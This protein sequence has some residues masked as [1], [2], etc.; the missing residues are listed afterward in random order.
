MFKALFT[1]FRRHQKTKVILR[2]LQTSASAMLK[3]AI[4]SD[5][6]GSISVATACGFL[7]VVL[8]VTVTSEVTGTAVFLATAAGPTVEAATTPVATLAVGDVSVEG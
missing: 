5:S 4:T 3:K 7:L 8:L 1:S 2:R 6:I